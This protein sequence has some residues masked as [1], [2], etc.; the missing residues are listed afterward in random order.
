MSRAGKVIGIVAGVVVLAAVAAVVAGQAGLLKGKTPTDLGVRDGRFKPPATS[1]NS[2]SSQAGLHADNPR[3]TSAAIAPLA[4]AGTPAQT[5]AKLRTVL[6][7]MPGA[8]IVTARD[9]YVYAQF[10]TRW[11]GFV[12]DV[13]FWVDPAAQVL[14]VRSASRLGESDLGANRARMEAIRSALAAAQ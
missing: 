13:E 1:P 14:Q 5:M 2:V 12:D 4:L 8:A 10:T 11:M 9:D 3:A 7:A 6:A